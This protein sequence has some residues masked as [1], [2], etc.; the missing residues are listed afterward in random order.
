MEDNSISSLSKESL[1]GIVDVFCKMIET[2]GYWAGLYANLYWFNNHLNKDYLKSRFTTWIAHW[3]NKDKLTML[4]QGEYDLWQYTNEQN[5]DGISG[6]VDGNFLH[7]DL[8]EE[9]GIYKQ[10]E[11][12]NNDLQTK[13]VEEL[14]NEVI[15]GLY[16]NGEERKQKLGSR[17]NE[18]Q[19]RVNEIL[20]INKSE[21]IIEGNKVRVKEGAVDY[22]GKGLASFVYQNVYDVIQTNGDRIVIGKGNQVTCAIKRENLIKV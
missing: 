13:S 14:A 1:T 6:N 3:V 12:M 17:Y 20:N 8:I 9:I 22:A 19:K 5:I 15:K 18:V 4:Y 10:K 11:N 2:K 21:E 16:G 7:R